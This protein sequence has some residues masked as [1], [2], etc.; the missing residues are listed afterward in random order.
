M[1]TV[2]LLWDVDHTLVDGGGVSRQTFDL[3]FRRLT[4]R[5]AAV[6]A[7]TGGRTDAAVMAGMLAD[8][9]VDPADVGWARQ[10]A[11]LVEAMTLT[12]DR[13]REHGR[14]LPGAE[15][16]LRALADA[17]GVLQSVLT[18]NI[19]ENARVKLGTFGLDR[20]VDLTIGGF[21][22]EQH[23]RW[24][25]VPL[26]QQRAR[27]RGFDPGRDVTVLVGDT[28]ADVEAG[29]IGGAR[30][31][32]VG[33]GEHTPEELRAAGADAALPGLGDVDAFLAALAGLRRSG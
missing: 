32:G 14:A 10:R 13:L 3:A 11:A 8:N 5:D 21:S 27:S 7:R 24:T 12:A 2:L 20:W 25:L 28:P 22:T 17:P 23:A 1:D 30:V 33:T 19:E 26:A 6:P 4:G 29:R 16:C 9:G 18:G 15:D 31:I